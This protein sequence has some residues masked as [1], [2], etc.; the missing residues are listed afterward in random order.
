M[1]VS[2]K[3]TLGALGLLVVIVGLI[4]LGANRVQQYEAQHPLSCISEQKLVNTNDGTLTFANGQ[5]LNENQLQGNQGS[6][7]IGNTYCVAYTRK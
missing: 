7:K 5:V 1:G 4:G 3:V 6:L 2:E